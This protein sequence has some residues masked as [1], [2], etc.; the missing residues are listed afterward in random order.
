MSEPKTIKI[1]EVEYVRKDSVKAPDI[2]GSVQ[3]AILQ[4]G[5]VC[6]GYFE[7]KGNDCFMKQSS[8][9]RRWGTTHGLGEIAKNG[10]TPNTKLDK[11]YGLVEFDILTVV[12]RLHCEE[13]KWNDVL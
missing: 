6:V 1:D 11:N 5:W 12:Q 8:T 4:R 9:I 2:K 7:R 3:I 13:L 10:P